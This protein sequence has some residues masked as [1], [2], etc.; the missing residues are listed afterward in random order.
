[1]KQISS[2][3]L[4][5]LMTELS[6]LENSKVE[7]IY[8]YGNEQFILQFYK[9][10]FGK[11]IL[12]IILGKVVYI[13]A[14]KENDETPSNFCNAL[15]K[16]IGGKFLTSVRQIK[17]ERIIRLV[18]K[19]TEEIKTLCLEFFGEGNLI[20]TDSED[21][22][23]QALSYHKFKDRN[24][25][26]KVKY[27]YPKMRHNIFDIN[28]KGLGEIFFNSNKDKIVTSL[29]IEL[30]AGGVYSEEVCTLSKV[31]KTINPKQIS[32]EDL[33]SIFKSIRKILNKEI[34][35]MGIFNEDKI[36]DAIPFE[37]A[38]Y[39]QFIKKPFV[40]FSEALDFYYSNFTPKQKTEHENRLENLKRI[41]EEQ[42][43]TLDELKTEESDLR[44]KGE[45]IYHNHM[46][47]NNILLEINNLVKKKSLEEIRQKLKEHKLIRSIDLKDKS[48]EVE[49]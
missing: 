29:A 48:I 38:F 46:L 11:L 8:N 4:N 16:N 17:P 9:S 22:I 39:N 6:I 47:I 23:L 30:G 34:N 7:N 31:D 45:A 14:K 44:D 15:R 25:V 28:E 43:A 20:I 24:V 35:P 10:N 42:K 27:V 32:E 36:I 40:K 19:S 49:I 2:L 12:K 3:E 1:M 18:F 13:S 37:L 33:S 21:T 41:I 26:P 5:F